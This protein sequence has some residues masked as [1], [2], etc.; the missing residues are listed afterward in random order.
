[1]PQ[2]PQSPPCFLTRGLTSSRPARQSHTTQ[3]PL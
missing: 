1:M 3:E 2:S